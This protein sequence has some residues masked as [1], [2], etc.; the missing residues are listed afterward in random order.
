MVLI[1]SC[2]GGSS[3][4]TNPLL[5]EKWDNP[6]NII[7]YD[8]IS[9][10]D[11][12]PAF[13]EAIS[14]QNS[15]IEA[16]TTDTLELTF[17]SV[18]LR[19]DNSD[20]KIADIFNIFSMIEA[21]NSTPDMAKVS[22]EMMPR[23]SAQ[24]DHVLH[25]TALF[26]RV[27]VI[28]DTRKISK[29]N[30]EQIRL[31]ERT[32]DKFVREGAL[33]DDE[34]KQ[35]LA[36]INETIALLRVEFSQNLLAEN[37]DYIMV[38]KREQMDGVTGAARNNALREAQDRGLENSWVIT[39]KPS[40]LIPFLTYSKKRELREEIYKAYINRGKNCN[41]YDNR[42]I[43]ETV[44]R[45]R[46]EKAKLLGHNNY[47]EYVTSQQMAGSPKAAY[48]L[49]ESVWTPALSVAQKELETL[50]ALMQRS[51]AYKDATFEPWD[52]WFF[53]EQVKENEYN[54][55]WD[56][57]RN[58]FPVEGVR[59]GMFLLAN[60]LY[61]L[62]FRPIVI[63]Q[64]Q[65][66]CSAYEVIDVDGK[67]LGILQLDL[68]TRDTKGQGAWC[69]Y[70]REQ[71]YEDGQRVAPIVSISC[72]FAI[73]E[74]DNKTLLTMSEVETIFHE[75][76]HALHF[77]FQDVKYRGLSEVE[78]DFVEL[79]SQIMENW[80]FQPELLRLYAVNNNNGEVLA[81][82][83]IQNIVRSMKFNQGF[84]TLE[85]TAAALLDL[86]LHTLDSLDGFDVNEFEITSLREK[87][88]L[89]PQISPRYYLPQFS[90]LFT[91]DYA[92]GYYFYM[93]AEVLDKDAFE[94]FKESGD[95][96][97]RAIANKF[98]RE[99]LE[100][101][102]SEDG[103]VM[104]RNFRGAAPSRDPLLLSRGL[105]EPPKVESENEENLDED[106]QIEDSKIEEDN[107]II[108]LSEDEIP[109]AS[110]V[111]TKKAKTDETK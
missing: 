38:L 103:A 2:E 107:K 87:R 7:P 105:I 55:K 80:A 18:I 79:P 29:L 50:E 27:K 25:N 86:D 58:Y 104:Y 93:W 10:K 53:A 96:F 63:A 89:I 44:T 66:R 75:F 23:L 12:M 49:M 76:G 36:T 47:A 88:G 81:E 39:L 46:Q 64:Y 11:Y 72:N 73:P 32:Y 40:S 21:S 37:N 5:V 90:H 99:I 111:V 19:L 68:Y 85:V 8:K 61:G 51:K 48:E 26:E 110:K 24:Q 92:S 65:E 34:A 84:M 77:L 43:I 67:L 35:R 60:R 62:T 3:Y 22:A 100:R 98:R 97:N 52:W 95:I 33:L 17:E 91:F 78:G 69:G 101:G 28:Y 74:D 20:V 4:H 9:A 108:V 16:I 94:V 71:R 59:S 106:N 42:E 102:G 70:L 82:G 54:V 30:R 83:H 41:E 14:D 15:I 109:T 57:L 45:L 56:M 31:T 13:E 1:S 6:H